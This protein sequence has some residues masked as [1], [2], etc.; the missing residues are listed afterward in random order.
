MHKNAKHLNHSRTVA[1]L[2]AS[3]CW[4]YASSFAFILSLSL[5]IFS[6]TFAAFSAIWALVAAAASFLYWI[7]LPW[8]L[9]QILDWKGHCLSCSSEL[10]KIHKIPIHRFFSLF[11]GNTNFFTFI[12]CKSFIR[13]QRFLIKNLN[14]QQIL[15]ILDACF[16]A[17]F[18]C[19]L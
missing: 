15:K 10:H 11:S 4:L 5:F 7:K 13:F 16:D 9:V 18:L 8:G 6:V 12:Y 2:F 14:Q 17:N 1:F 3:F 19:I